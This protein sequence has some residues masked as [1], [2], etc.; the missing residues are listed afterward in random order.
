MAIGL[1]REMED[2]VG[3][4]GVVGSFSL[5]SLSHALHFRVGTHESGILFYLVNTSLCVSY[6]VQL[7]GILL[8]RN[9]VV[10]NV[11]RHHDWY[12]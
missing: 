2:G 10:A 7:W 5:N 4:M 8:V 1:S 6:P 3:I 11:I 9:N 12:Q